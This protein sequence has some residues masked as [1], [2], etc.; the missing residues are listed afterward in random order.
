[1]S[2][3]PLILVR[4]QTYLFLVFLNLILFFLRKILNYVKKIFVCVILF[5]SPVCRIQNMKTVDGKPEYKG[6]I[7]VIVK[8]AKKEGFFKLWKGFTPYYFR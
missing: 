4:S 2:F 6:A 8:V 3:N 5:F 7:D 1:M